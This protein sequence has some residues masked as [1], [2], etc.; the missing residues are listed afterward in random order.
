MT[1]HNIGIIG[2]GGFGKFLH[3]AWKSLPSVE[4]K[5]IADKDENRNPGAPVTFYNSWRDLINDPAIDIVSVVTP[6]RTH[7]E[8]ACA[9]LDAGKHVLVEKPLA[10]TFRDAEKIIAA[11]DRSG[12]TAAIDFMQ[13]FNP[14][15]EALHH[16]GQKNVFGKLR[17]VDVENYAQDS[18]LS[19]DHWFWN[20]DIGGG[21]LV[22]H[23]VHFIDIVHFLT[24]VQPTRIDGFSASTDGRR[25]NQVVANVVYEDGLIATHYHSFTRPGFFE[26]TSIRLSYD[27]AQIDLHGWIPLTGEIRVLVN[28]ETEKELSK[29]PGFR[30]IRTQKIN[31]IEDESRPEGWG[32]DDSIENETSGTIRSGTTDYQ[33]DKMITAKLDIGKSKAEVYQ[34]SVRSVMTD[35]IKAIEN[36]EHR[37]RTPLESGLLSLDVAIQATEA[38]RKKE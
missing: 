16:L 6:P 11:R 27:L 5:A 2:Y 29:L 37:L 14:I 3:N 28:S 22:E 26:D 36:S 31:E 35:L 24:D 38:G 4:I 23:A 18:S 20:P 21:I 8:I 9:A 30:E 12:K 15:V 34:Q 33:I 25:E 19:D 1:N 10:V 7:A 17:R 32:S 13:R